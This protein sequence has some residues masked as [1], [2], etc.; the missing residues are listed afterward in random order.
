MKHVK[1]KAFLFTSLI[2]GVLLLSACGSNPQSAGSNDPNAS[3]PSPSAVSGSQRGNF[4][5]PDV[6][7]EVKS[8]NGNDISVAL[9]E[10]PQ[11]PQRN[12]TQGSGDSTAPQGSKPQGTRPSGTGNG[13]RQGGGMN[14]PKKYTGATQT[15]TVAADTQISTFERGSGNG[16]GNGNNRPTQK[17]IK[18]SDIKAGS[19]IQVWYKSGTKEI[20]RIMVM[21]VPAAS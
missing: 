20:Q 1:I 19:I 17:D 10:M 11:R 15:V 21:Q 14:A 18:V 6:Y 16:N 7:G 5:A 4:A 13:Q 2:S 3:S 8:V 12:N 9:L